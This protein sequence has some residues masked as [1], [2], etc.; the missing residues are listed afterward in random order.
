MFSRNQ[1]FHELR[2]KA[3]GL[4]TETLTEEE[5]LQALVMAGHDIEEAKLQIK[6]MKGLGSSILI[7]NRMICLAQ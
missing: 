4:P 6:V 2:G 1:K 3:K 7:D 5:C